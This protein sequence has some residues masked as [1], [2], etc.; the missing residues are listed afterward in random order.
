[1]KIVVQTVQCGSGGKSLV[2]KRVKHA[3]GNGCRKK[4]LPL[5]G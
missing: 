4:I 1:M 5:E 2:A 3:E